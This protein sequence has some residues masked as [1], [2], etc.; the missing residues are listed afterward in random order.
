MDMTTNE[1]DRL[2]VLEMSDIN[3]DNLRVNDLFL[4]TPLSDAQA[5]FNVGYIISV[6]EVVEIRNSNI[7]YMSRY[8]KLV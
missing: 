3:T 8:F 5:S 7:V 4:T 2:P 1:Y 6:Y